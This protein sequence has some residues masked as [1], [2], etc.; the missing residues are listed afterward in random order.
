MDNGVLLLSVVVAFIAIFALT[1]VSTRPSRKMETRGGVSQRS[2]GE[3]RSRSSSRDRYN[4]DDELD[5]VIPAVIMADVLSD[6]YESNRG[7]SSDDSPR[8]SYGS[9]SYS[10]GGSSYDS[11]G[12]SDSGGS[13]GGCD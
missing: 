13:D 6:D 11:G 7:Y 3:S 5:D 12:S 2:R 4:H 9:D 8:S 1:W 10:S